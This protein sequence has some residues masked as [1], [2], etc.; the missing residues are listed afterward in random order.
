MPQAE[1][2]ESPQRYDWFELLVTSFRLAISPK[3]LGLSLVGLVITTLAWQGIG[4]A[5]FPLIGTAEDS[6]EA[7]AVHDFG[8]VAS[9]T[10]GHVLADLVP[11][12]LANAWWGNR[13]VNTP[14]DPALEVPYRMVEPFR[15][16]FL[17]GRGWASL[18][19]YLG[20]GLASLAVWALFGGAITRFAIVR[21]STRDPLSLRDAM[22]FAVAKWRDFFLG[23]AL[24]LVGIAMLAFPIIAFGWLLSLDWGVLVGSVLWLGVLLAAGLMAILSLGLMFGWPLMWGTIGAESSDG[25]DAISRAYGYTMHRPLH[26]AWYAAT[27]VLLGTAGWLLAW[28]MTETTINLSYWSISL[29]CGNERA[30]QLQSLAETGW[31]GGGSMLEIGANIMGLANRAVQICASAFS[32]SYFWCAT[33][34]MYLLL[35][36]AKDGTPLDEIVGK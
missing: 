1:T 35:R 32:Y 26:Y 9:S 16:L 36:R 19:Y 33:S 24:K 2:V 5:L 15:R 18:A 8:R 20:G 30:R 27:A 14:I 34:A 25:F 13:S 17:I 31:Q 29:G 7:R 12:T 4:L 23:P 3:C 11:S 28:W 6:P 10:Q 21:L 22:R